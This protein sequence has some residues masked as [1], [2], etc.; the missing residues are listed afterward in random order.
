[1]RSVLAFFESIASGVGKTIHNPTGNLTATVVLLAGVVL[2]FMIALV[3]ILIWM[4]APTAGPRPSSTPASRGPRA[5]RFERI[6]YVVAAVLAVLYASGTLY[7]KSASTS[8]CE[9]CHTSKS[10]VVASWSK[11]VHRTQPCWSCHGGGGVLGGVEARL[12]YV[13]WV[14]PSARATDI[15][16]RAQVA[17]DVCTRCHRE[18]IKGTVTVGEVRIRHAEPLAKGYHCVD[19]HSETGHRSSSS[20]GRRTQQMQVCI[21]CHDGKTA[22]AECTTCHVED[23]GRIRATSAD[24]LP[25]VEMGAPQTC[26]GCHSIKK[27][28]DCH[29]LEMPHTLLFMSTGAHAKEA[30]FERHAVCMKCHDEKKFCNRCHRFADGNHGGASWR[31]QHGTKARALGEDKCV[32]CHNHSKDFCGLCHGNVE[33]SVGTPTALVGP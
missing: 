7:V 30:A 27:C 16:T 3:A 12:A 8:T 5:R 19:C 4:L 18:A 11:G 6:A 1:M 9:R 20:A 22:T 24:E 29:G 33:S 2:V 31:L 14:S 32:L 21:L 15:K 26:R 10:A 13:R 23:V 17:D 28:N 25:K